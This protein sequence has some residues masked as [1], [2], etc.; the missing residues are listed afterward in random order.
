MDMNFDW[1]QAYTWTRDALGLMKAAKDLLPAG[2]QREEATVKIE[3]AERQLQLAEAGVAK[4]LG[5]HL[6]QC[7]FPPSIMLK[8]GHNG[9]QDI[10]TCPKCSA[11]YPPPRATHADTG[12]GPGGWMGV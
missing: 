12:P 2:K 6:C 4:G 7:A 10:L 8:T 5:Y 1:G 9:R 3:Q 11:S